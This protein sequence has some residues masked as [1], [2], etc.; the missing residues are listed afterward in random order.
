M[1]EMDI[2]NVQ[3]AI[4]PKVSKPDTV[5]VFCISSHSALHLC[6]VLWKYFWWYQ[7]WR[8][9]KWWKHWWTDV[10]TNGHLL[11]IT[12]LI[13]GSKYYPTTPQKYPISASTFLGTHFWTLTEYMASTRFTS[14]QYMQIRLLPDGWA[15]KILEGITQYPCHFLWRGIKTLTNADILI[16]A[17]ALPIL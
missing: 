16:T 8:G 5:H 6:E 7:L 2:F 3:R 10:H 1:V 17:I 9:H 15:F 14:T 12:L 4:T 11:G 13:F